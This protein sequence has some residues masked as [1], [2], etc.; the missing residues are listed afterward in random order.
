[1]VKKAAK[2]A[3]KKAA[4][5]V[6]KKTPSTA[7]RKSGP[8]KPSAGSE[9]G[10]ERKKANVVSTAATKPKAVKK[11]VKKTATSKP[12]TGAKTHGDVSGMSLKAGKL[13]GFPAAPRR[14]GI[15]ID[16]DTRRLVQPGP[17]GRFQYPLNLICQLTIEFPRGWQVGTGWFG[18]FDVLFTAGHCIF[19]HKLGGMARSIKV[20]VPGKGYVKATKWGSTAEWENSGSEVDDFGYLRVPLKTK[21]FFNYGDFQ[22]GDFPS[23]QFY[24]FGYPNEKHPGQQ[25]NGPALWGQEGVLDRAG[26]NQIFY[27]IDTGEGQS[28]APVFCWNDA[29]ADVGLPVAVGIHNY[30]SDRANT[31][32]AT[33]ITRSIADQLIL[34]SR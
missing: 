28:G 20:W 2:K 16:R 15:V 13:P 17:A 7:G 32:Y 31:N 24:V 9:T 11:A 4:R 27:S 21:S 22:A 25:S 33:R 26:A 23:K 30:G 34:W 3:V 19:S 5:T 14:K 10:K 29:G 12:V 6:S 18:G 1:V 8:G